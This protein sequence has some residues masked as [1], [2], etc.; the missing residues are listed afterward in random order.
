MENFG[1]WLS[2]TF[3]TT[4]AKRKSWPFV[5][6]TYFVLDPDAPVAVTTLKVETENVGIE[7]IIRNVISNPAIRFLLMV[8]DEPPKHLTGETFRCLFS[9][10]IESD[11]RKIIGSPGMRPVLPSVTPDELERFVQQVELVDMIECKDAAAIRDKVHELRQ[12]NPG[13]FEGED[14]NVSGELAEVPVV[15][16][17]YH[18]PQKIKLDKAGYFVVNIEND[19]IL[20]EHYN[21]KDTLIR[22]IRGKTAR[23]MYLTMVDN[24][25]ISRVDHA[26][27]VGKELTK[28]ELSI[29]YGFAYQQDG[30]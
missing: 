17:V 9:N 21:Y 2:R 19:E 22:H 25:W 23:D 16:E 4:K 10:G 13:V 18:D 5:P 24:G 7:K 26:C 14:I 11:T 27:Y 6:G 3:A 20:C 1:F 12:R 30:A 8:G 29:L 15:H 28:A